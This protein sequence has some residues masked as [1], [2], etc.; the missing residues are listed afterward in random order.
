MRRSSAL[1]LCEALLADGALVRVYD[2]AV[3]ALPVNLATRITV[4][5]DAIDAARGA[6]AIVV[7]TEWPEF[8]TAAERLMTGDGTP[9]VLDAN[10]F[11]SALLG[12]APRMCY[13][14][15]GRP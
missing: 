1:E 5:R 2:P 12:P 7:A 15:V 13:I 9:L 3:S 11:L 8:L 4:G 14:T 6:D 10:G